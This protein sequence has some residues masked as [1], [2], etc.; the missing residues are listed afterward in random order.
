MHNLK[1]PSVYSSVNQKYLSRCI[2]LRQF[3]LIKNFIKL[4]KVI[5][6]CEHTELLNVHD[7]SRLM[8]VMYKAICFS[9]V[10]KIVVRSIVRAFVYL[11]LVRWPT[12][13]L[14][15]Q[16]RLSMVFLHY[17]NTKSNYCVYMLFRAHPFGCNQR[18][19]E[20]CI[21]TYMFIVYCTYIYMDYT[22]SSV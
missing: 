13:A 17:C 20:Q 18:P 22:C 10:P 16:L 15:M 19:Y 5:Q 12:S 21:A 7:T 11:S 2:Y 1:N 3:H 14:I 6:W 4:I 9:C 8:C